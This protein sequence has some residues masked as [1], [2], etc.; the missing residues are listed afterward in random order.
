MRA[1]DLEAFAAA[2]VLAHEL[3]VDADHVIARLLKACAVVLVHLPGRVLFLGPLHPPDVVVVPL[4]A[5][6]AGEIGL[7]DLLAFVEYVSFVH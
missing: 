2:D 3:I 1:R 4:A 5:E 6:R 7:F